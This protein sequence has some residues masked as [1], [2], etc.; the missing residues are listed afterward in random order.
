MLLVAPNTISSVRS[1]IDRELRF[2][3]LDCAFYR[4]ACIAGRSILK[5]LLSLQ[6]M[7]CQC[8]V[9]SKPDPS[10]HMLFQSLLTPDVNDSMSC[11][12]V[13]PC[14]KAGITLRIVGQNTVCNIVINPQKP[15]L[16]TMIFLGLSL[17]PVRN[18]F[19]V[20]RSSE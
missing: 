1:Y 12:F 19:V 20:S 14:M 5:N 8:W 9:E 16:G 7:F 11:S 6:F 13:Y 4:R 2:G 15:S 10:K 18:P 17:F 3:Y